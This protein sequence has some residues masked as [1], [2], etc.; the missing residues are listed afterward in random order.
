LLSKELIKKDKASQAKQHKFWVFR[1]LD[2][3]RNSKEKKILRPKNGIVFNGFRYFFERWIL[4]I[5][6]Y[7][8]YWKKES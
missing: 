6:F 5:V 7:G 4:G 8:G 1:G 3:F 2:D